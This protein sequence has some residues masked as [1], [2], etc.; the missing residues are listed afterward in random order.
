MTKKRNKNDHGQNK[1]Q[2]SPRRSLPQFPLIGKTTRDGRP[3]ISMRVK[4]VLVML[5]TAL[6]VTLVALVAIPAALQIFQRVNTQPERVEERLESYVRSFAEYVAE[7]KLSSED[8]AAVVEWTRRHDSVFLT[9]FNSGDGHFGAAGGEFWEEGSRPDMAPFFHKVLDEEIASSTD[10]YS[11]VYVV[12]FTNGL[13]SIAVVDYSLA[14]G[15]DTV[16]IVGVLVAVLIFFIVLMLYYHRQTRAIVH[17]SRDVEA[18]SGGALD[19]AIG[20]VRRDEIGKLAEDV[21]IMRNTILEKM[22]EQERAWQANSD[23]LTSMTHDIRTPLTT[24][25]GYM[26]ILG[27][28]NSNLTEE[29]RGY[30]R[31]CTQKAEQIKGLSDKLFLYF[32]AFNRAETENASDYESFEAGLLF[33]QLIGDYI[34]AM[35]AVGLRI[36]ADL[37]AIQP[38]DTLHVRIDCLRRVT[39]NIFDNMTK[40]ADRE[41]P[42]TIRAERGD[43]VL[44]LSFTNTVNTRA[45]NASG[46]RIGVKTCVNMMEMMK[47]RFLTQTEGETFTAS[48]TLPLSEHRGR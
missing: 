30:I 47:G 29:Q 44:T 21:D 25:L 36:F 2:G 48:L 7:E 19:A 23:L 18:I 3:F 28:D 40:Y 41:S 45:E 11:L 13:H 24:L 39:D 35:E 34:P 5:V 12:R 20:V 14:T 37:S 46:T 31:V 16:I 22:E 33:E 26:E 15:T 32:W 1:K 17:L 38:A 42:V 27:G 6:A 43:D 10:E 9:V 8:T 4:F